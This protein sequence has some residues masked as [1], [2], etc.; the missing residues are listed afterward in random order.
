MV[1]R[2]RN[3]GSSIKTKWAHFVMAAL[4]CATVAGCVAEEYEKETDAI[5]A[6]LQEAPSSSEQIKFDGELVVHSSDILQLSDAVQSAT[7]ESERK[8]IIAE[9]LKSNENINCILDEIQ[10]ALTEETD[11]N[12]GGK[13]L[14]STSGEN[15][16]PSVSDIVEDL[17]KRENVADK[18]EFLIEY[19]NNWG[20]V[21]RVSRVVESLDQIGRT[22][23]LPILGTISRRIHNFPILY[24]GDILVPT[25]DIPSL[26]EQF[27]VTDAKD[28]KR[29]LVT[30][31]LSG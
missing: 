14:V 22:H 2:M 5:I 17:N 7:S 15:G 28:A 30:S 12:C 3:I 16:L 6:R 4:V 13:A 8:D 10:Q 20:K 18:R 1:M 9:Y 24:E 25:S 23:A 31:Y 11:L 29:N 26:L 19:L 21:Q 27:E